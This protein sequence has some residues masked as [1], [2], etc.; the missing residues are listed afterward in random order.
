MIFEKT[1]AIHYLQ[2]SKKHSLKEVTK[3]EQLEMY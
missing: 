1:Q 2:D 3:K